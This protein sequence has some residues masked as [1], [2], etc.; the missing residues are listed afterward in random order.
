MRSDVATPT[1]AASIP[2]QSGPTTCSAVYGVRNSNWDFATEIQR[3]LGASASVTA[4]YYRNWYG[5]FTVTDNLL[6]SPADFDPYCITAPLNRNLPGGGGY[7]VCGLYDVSLAKFTQVDN[8]VTQSSNYGQQKQINDFFNVSI[9]TRFR[10]GIQLGWRLSI[11]VVRPP[12]TASWWT[13]QVL[14]PVR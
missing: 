2:P 13:R 9:N 4:G 3:Q 6:R 11:R 10:S 7:Q 8:L 12:T 1:S 14:R 5:N